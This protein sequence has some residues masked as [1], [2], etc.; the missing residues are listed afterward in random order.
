M[1]PLDRLRELTTIALRAESV[2]LR[3][4]A[5]HY[6][7]NDKLTTEAH[8]L[9]TLLVLKLNAMANEIRKET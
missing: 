9:A 6:A 5:L 7:H 2:M 3:L 4:A 1:T 8:D